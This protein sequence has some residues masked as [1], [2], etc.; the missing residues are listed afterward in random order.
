MDARTLERLPVLPVL[1]RTV[2]QR[3]VQAAEL[4]EAA[5]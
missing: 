2:A 1:A 4:L 5:R 3:R